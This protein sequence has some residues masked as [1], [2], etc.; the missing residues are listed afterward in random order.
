MNLVYKSGAWWAW[1]VS[2]SV[3]RGYVYGVEPG[4]EVGHS[5]CAQHWVDP[6]LGEPEAD[7]IWQEAL[8]KKR[9]RTLQMQKYRPWV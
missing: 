4:R 3:L 8:F 5:D 2:G 1:E 7:T 9:N 6:S